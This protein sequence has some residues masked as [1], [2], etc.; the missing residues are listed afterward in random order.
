MA[1]I[2]NFG[3]KLKEL[4]MILCQT[5]EASSG[6]RA[7]IREHYVEL[8]GKN[9][10]VPILVRECSGV[11][12]KIYARF[13]KGREANV[14]VSNLNSSEILRRLNDLASSG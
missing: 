4:R 11:V 14:N 5:S 9:P 10:Q 13:E 6:I 12:P 1:N 7:F 8:K 3:P 2:A